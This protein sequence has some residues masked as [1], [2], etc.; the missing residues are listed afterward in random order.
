MSMGYLARIGIRIEAIVTTTQFEE[1]RKLK[2]DPV[3]NSVSLDGVI[4]WLRRKH[5]IVI[6]NSIEPFVDPVSDNHHIL[7]RFSVKR[8]NLRDGWNGRE[9][10][11][12]SKLTKNIYTAKKQAI[13]LAIKWLKQHRHERKKKI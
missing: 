11:G 1:L 4:D 6:Y 2:F 13:T 9:Y 8:C 12:E 3:I 7:Y 10:I 5:N